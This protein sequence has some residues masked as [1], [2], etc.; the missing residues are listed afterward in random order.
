M[1]KARGKKLDLQVLTENS[2]LIEDPDEIDKMVETFYK[3]LYDKYNV[4]DHFTVSGDLYKKQ[5]AAYPVD[6]IV[7][8][9]KEASARKLPAADLP[10][11]YSSYEQLKEKL[12]EPSLVSKGDVSPTRVD[13]GAVTEGRG[14]QQGLDRGTVGQGIRPSPTG[15]RP[16]EGGTTGVS[17]AGATPS[18]RGKPAGGLRGEGQPELTNKPKLP[19]DQRPVPSEPKRIEPR[20]AAST[21]GNKPGA[22]G[23]VGEVSLPARRSGATGRN[24]EDGDDFEHFCIS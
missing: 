4:V 7:I 19:E 8:A 5:G 2:A 9:G 24:E 14:E 20:G 6:V 23:G 15:E 11:V 10:K 13:S 3:N 21:E 12:N 22:V 17:G 1:Q 16:A 18:G